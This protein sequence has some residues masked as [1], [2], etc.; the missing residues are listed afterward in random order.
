[1]VFRPTAA[2]KAETAD[3][4][5]VAVGVYSTSLMGRH[6]S[7]C[8]YL[9]PGLYSCL[10]EKV[11]EEEKKMQESSRRHLLLLHSI[12]LVLR[13]IILLFRPHCCSGD[14]PTP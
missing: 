5:R 10:G 9:F 11:S 14:D 4:L 2:P 1:M 8:L 13:G 6:S 7:T 3:P 12:S